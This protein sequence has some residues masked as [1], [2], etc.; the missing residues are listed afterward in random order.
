[1]IETDSA[2]SNVANPRVRRG[3]STPAER[4]QWR[5]RFARSGLS[6]REF[7]A[8]NHLGLQTLYRWLSEKPGPAPRKFKPA[9]TELQLPMAAGAPRWAAE[10]LRAN[11]SL[12]RLAHDVPQ[13]LLE[14]L[15]ET[16]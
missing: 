10:V 1:M 12:V 14:R 13:T 15:L 11:G 5:E 8:Q 2:V 7:A 3:R 9:F 6:R 16:C 4:A